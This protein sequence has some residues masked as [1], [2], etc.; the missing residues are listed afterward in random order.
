MAIW[1]DGKIQ[2]VEIWSTPTITTLREGVEYYRSK[3]PFTPEVSCLAVAG[4]IRDGRAVLTNS[5][6]SGSKD[7]LPGRN[8]RLI[9]DLYAAAR[10]IELLGPE[11]V[12]WMGA[13]RPTT[14]DIVA[15]MGVGTGHGQAFRIGEQIIASEGGHTEF[16][17]AT[18]TQDALL[19]WMREQYGR[20]SLEQVGSGPAMAQVLAFCAASAPL[21]AAA[22]DA[23]SHQ[24]AAAV[25]FEMADSEPACAA[26][27]DLFLSILGSAAGDLA[28]R[29]MPDGGVYIV[30]GVRARIPERVTDGRM[31]A[32]FDNNAPMNGTVH[33]LPFAPAPEPRTGLLGAAA[34]ATRVL[35]AY[36]L[37]RGDAC[38]V[39]V[40]YPHCFPSGV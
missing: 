31:R 29:C 20:V 1:D 33:S 19:R 28:L 5:N 24:P 25:V 13:P 9:N 34:E 12:H 38:G 23:L 39:S 17:P 32:A 14:A 15:V 3:H 40:W 21:S 37:R 30:G 11:H 8:P 27:L 36:R 35:Q 2:A 4:P 10:G 22:V 6:W 16:G 7:D 26:A 18:P